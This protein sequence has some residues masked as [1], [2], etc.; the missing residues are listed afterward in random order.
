MGLRYSMLDPMSENESCQYL[1]AKTQEK[2]G[3]S[4]NASTCCLTNLII[5]V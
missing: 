3:L 1:S 4:E 2:T 5:G